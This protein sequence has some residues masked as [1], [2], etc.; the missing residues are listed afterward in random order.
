MI[1]KCSLDWFQF[2][3]LDITDNRKKKQFGRRGNRTRACS[4]ANICAIHC[5]VVATNLTILK[6]ACL[7]LG[8]IF[9]I[10]HSQDKCICVA[11]VKS[12]IFQ[13]IHKLKHELAQHRGSDPASQ[14]VSTDLNPGPDFCRDDNSS[15]ALRLRSFS[16]AMWLSWVWNPPID[17]RGI[18]NTF[19]FVL[20]RA[21][22]RVRSLGIPSLELHRCLRTAVSF[23]LSLSLSLCHSLT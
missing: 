13:S 10:L 20:V 15:E 1:T 2:T 6:N 19:I 4:L 3:T 17:F 12:N 22:P 11:Q 16:L 9:Y 8:Y 18:R 5:V 14:P 21:S 23:F 7:M